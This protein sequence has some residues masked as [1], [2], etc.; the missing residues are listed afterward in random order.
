MVYLARRD[1]IAQAN[2]TRSSTPRSSPTRS[3]DK[4]AAVGLQARSRAVRLD[5]LDGLFGATS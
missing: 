5:E 2:G 1:A 4:R 3:P